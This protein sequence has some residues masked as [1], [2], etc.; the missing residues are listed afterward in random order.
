MMQR[1][2]VKFSLRGKSIFTTSALSDENIS[3][4]MKRNDPRFKKAI[5]QIDEQGTPL[6]LYKVAPRRIDPEYIRGDF[7]GDELPSLAVA[8]QKQAKIKASQQQAKAM[9]R[10]RNQRKY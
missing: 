2:I 6:I 7:D 8:I 1:Y 9:A 4:E 10:S 5:L 3:K